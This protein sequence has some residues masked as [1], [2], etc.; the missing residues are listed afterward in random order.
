MPCVANNCRGDF[1]ESMVYAGRSA[2]AAAMGIHNRFH[3][4]IVQSQ[5]SRDLFISHGVPEKRVHL[6]RNFV[7]EPTVSE[8]RPSNAKPYVLFLGR[9]TPEKGIGD[10]VALANRMPGLSI[11]VA[12]GMLGSPV[13]E[14]PGNVEFLGQVSPADA[15]SLL[16][17]ASCLLF[18]SRWFEMCPMVLLEAMRFRTPVV[19]TAIGGIPELITH[20]ERGLLYAPGDIAALQSC[21][22]RVLQAGGLREALVENAYRYVLTAHSPQTH[23][24]QLIGVYGRVVVGSQVHG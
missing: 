3:G 14:W 9:I 16:R 22:S 1:V 21:I 15:Q 6:L 2:I 20:G 10:V 5:F 11:K 4:Y 19:A 13:V 7:G 18:S 23:Y 8:H 17:G 24:E 12:G